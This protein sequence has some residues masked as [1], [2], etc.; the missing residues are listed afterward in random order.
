MA[1]FIKSQYA[2]SESLNTE[3]SEKIEQYKEKLEGLKQ[4]A[5]TQEIEYIEKEKQISTFLE[6]KKHFW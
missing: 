1:S 5:A 3:T 4:V 6:C 2:V